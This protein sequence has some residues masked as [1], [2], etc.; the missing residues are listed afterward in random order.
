MGWKDLDG[1]DAVQARVPRAVHFSHASS[2]ERRQDFVRA[3]AS[4][5]GQC[6]NGVDY[7]S[8]NQ[9]AGIDLDFQTKPQRRR[10]FRIEAV[11]ERHA[12]FILFP[13]RLSEPG[14]ENTT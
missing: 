3:E 12:A 6:H 9:L 1:D 5:R 4:A 7:I 14:I 13:L 10:I 8:S 2:A 11:I